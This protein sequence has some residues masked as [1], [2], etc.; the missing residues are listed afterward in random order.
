[1]LIH[2]LKDPKYFFDTDNKPKELTPDEARS[3]TEKAIPAARV[4]HYIDS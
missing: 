1:M 2:D 4:R 3:E